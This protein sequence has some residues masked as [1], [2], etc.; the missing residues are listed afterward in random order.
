VPGPGRRGGRLPFVALAVAV[1]GAAFAA[2]EVPFLSGRVNDYARLLSDDA[3]GRLE[4]TLAEIERTTGAQVVVLTVETL[5]DEAI[6]DYSMHVAETWKLG[7]KGKNNG[8]LLVVARDDHKM[9]IEVGYGLEGA[10]TDAQ[11]SRIIAELMRP[12]FRDGDFAGGLDAAVT[13]IG[14]FIRGENPLPAEAPAGQHGQEL[15]LGGRLLF[16]AVFTVV[17]GVFS[18]LAVFMPGCQAWFLY[19]FLMPFYF[20]FPMAFGGLP[21]G[22]GMLGAWVVGFP[23]AKLL[24]GKTAGG[25]AWLK[26]HPGWATIA[27]SG[28]HG[29]SSHGWSSGGGFS[30]GGFSGGGGSFGGGGSSGSW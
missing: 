9:R 7:Q 16:A 8:V 30:S 13:A 4:S 27:A 3:H 11:C 22:V 18:L 15:S 23:V 28:G 17:V 29:G 10:L 20:A 2:T 5:G 19:A 26:R 14:G 1:A 12:R 24:L 6:E 25:R 21:V